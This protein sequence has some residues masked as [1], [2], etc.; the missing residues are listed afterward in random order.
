MPSGELDPDVLATLRA[1][2]A[3]RV[4]FIVIGD[5][6]DVLHGDKGGGYVA[7]LTIVPSGF[8]RNVDRL[9]AMLKELEADLRVP[10]ESQTLPV[11]LAKLREL[12]RCTLATELADIGIDFEPPGTAGYADLYADA[13]R[14]QLPA[15][16]APH[17]A[18]VEDLDR[19][20]DAT[21]SAAPRALP[22]ASP[23]H[24]R[25]RAPVRRR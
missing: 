10:G 6:A 24:A 25:G 20:E 13:R 15:G 11:D 4:E 9:V 3:G 18:S 16:A 7:A 14:V 8:A 5:A 21:R 23:A 12:G 22:T 1:L 2:E 19:I 17:V